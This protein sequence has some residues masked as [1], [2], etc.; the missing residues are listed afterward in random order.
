MVKW[1]KKLQ[2]LSRLTPALKALKASTLSLKKAQT[3]R[4]KIYIADNSLSSKYLTAITKLINR[5]EKSWLRTKTSLRQWSQIQIINSRSLES[6]CTLK[7]TTS[8]AVLKHTTMVYLAMSLVLSFACLNLQTPPKLPQASLKT[9]YLHTAVKH[10]KKR[11]QK[12]I[13]VLKW[14][15]LG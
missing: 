2:Q 1:I 4:I 13:Q 6:I 12:E 3:N 11:L 10:R 9:I 15:N 8:V 14:W 7:F 5:S